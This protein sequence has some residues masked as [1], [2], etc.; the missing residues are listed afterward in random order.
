[1]Q[2]IACLLDPGQEMMPNDQIQA[3]FG[4]ST[5]KNHLSFFNGARGKKRG[6]VICKKYVTFKFQYEMAT[7]EY[8]HI[9]S[10]ADCRW[11]L[12]SPY[13]SRAE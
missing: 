5:T 2:P 12:F 9:H 4:W 13:N 3:V 8:G 10:L 6:S 1:M 7:L 11:I